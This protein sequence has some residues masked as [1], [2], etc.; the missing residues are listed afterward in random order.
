MTREC[1][2]QQHCRGRYMGVVIRFPRHHA[3]A[4]SGYKSGRSSEREIPV[5]RSIGKTNSAGTPRFERESQYQTWD[6]VVPI[7]S[8]KGFCPPTFLHARCNADFDDM[9]TEYPNLGQLQPK[10]LCKQS[11]G[12]FGSVLGMKAH[13][14]DPALFGKRVRER[15]DELGWSQGRLAKESGQSQSNVG[16]IELGN[17]KDPEKQAL[18][19]ARALHLHVDWLLY[20]TGPRETARPLPSPKEIA[21]LYAEL[22]DEGKADLLR[23]IA[24]L[25]GNSPPSAIPGTRAK[26]LRETG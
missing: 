26:R 24:K 10:N 8:A 15:R 25:T 11:Y 22:P 9:S 19:L 6:C 5:S 17:A 12:K 18:K 13:S 23:M 14:I 16:W 21:A 3:R 20:G 4:S 7:R 2:K 1:A